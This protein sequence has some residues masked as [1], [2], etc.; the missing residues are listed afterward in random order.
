MN[1]QASV[2]ESRLFPVVETQFGKIR[3]INHQGV[4]TFKGIRY[5]ATTTGKNRFMPPQ[6]PQPWVGILDAFDYGEISPQT[7]ADRRGDYTNLIMWDAQPGGIGEDCLR[8][9]VWT[10]GLNDNAKRAVYVIFHGGGFATGS[11]NA[12]GFDGYD[13]ARHEDVVVVSVTHR[14]AAFGYLHLAGLGAPEEFKYAGVT[15]IMDMVASLKWVRNNISVFGGDPNRVMIFGQSGGGAKTS[16]LLATPSAKGLFQ[17]AAVQS[18]SALRLM[19]PEAGT[20]SA[21]MLLDALGLNKDNIAEIQNL[22]FTTL[23]AAQASFGPRGVNFSP[24]IGN[25][26]LPHHPFSPT[27]PP[28]SADIPVIISTTLDDAAIAL[29]NFDLSETELKENLKRDY[30]GNADRVYQL[31]RDTYPRVTPYLIQARI[32][33]DRGFRN[34]AIKQAELKA[35]QKGAAVY[36]YIWE[37]PVPTYNGKFGAVHGVDV[38]SAIHIYREPM[39]GCGHKEGML[40]VERLSAVWANFAKTG[41][42]NSEITPAWPAFNTTERPTMVFDLNTR[43]ENDY[44]REFRMLWNELGTTGNL[45]G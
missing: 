4:K 11:G 44:R 9:N 26:F 36:Y 10:R 42:P 19:E 32:A 2:M 16:T 6:P 31:Y 13:A 17:R 8:L 35:D 3:G 39:T 41:V 45:L 29:A 40:M 37:W 7:P 1:T 14:L 33:T 12:M 43:V 34:S 20:K 28:E 24:V 27:A 22:P 38:G 21:Q 5:G 25:D 15:G 23:L 18:G 30:A